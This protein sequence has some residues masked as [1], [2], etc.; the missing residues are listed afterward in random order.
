MRVRTGSPWSPRHRALIATAPGT[1][2]STHACM[3]A[4][5]EPAPSGVTGLNASLRSHGA[6]LSCL[7]A[8]VLSLVL[9]R[10][11]HCRSVR[12]C[13]GARPVAGRHRTLAVPSAR[14]VAR[15]DC[16]RSGAE[17][18]PLPGAARFRVRFVAVPLQ[19]RSRVSHQACGRRWH[20]ASRWSQLP[21]WT[22]SV[23]AQ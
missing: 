21:L 2:V 15:L 6:S 20:G 17:S 22:R 3:L 23:E 16:G 13:L 5:R 14:M 12:G 7:V 11:S 18:W 8:R 10:P 4:L 1:H 19:P 9:P